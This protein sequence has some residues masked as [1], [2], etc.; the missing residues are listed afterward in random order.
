MAAVILCSWIFFHFQYKS[1]LNDIQDVVAGQ[2]GDNHAVLTALARANRRLEL[3]T[4][5][6]GKKILLIRNSKGW[7]TIEKHGVIE[8]Q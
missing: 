4:R 3:S 2:I 1:R 5:E 6:N 8:F 7:T